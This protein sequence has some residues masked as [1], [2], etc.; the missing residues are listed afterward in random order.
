M[1]QKLAITV[2]VADED[3]RQKALLPGAEPTAKEREQITNPDVWEE[4]SSAAPAGEP[5]RG[6]AGVTTE[7]WA[8]YAH[9]LG[10]TVPEDASRDEIIAAV[11]ASRG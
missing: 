8:T 7:A 9:V 4:E 6:G 10:V 11:D 1:G 2:F 3:G 5:P